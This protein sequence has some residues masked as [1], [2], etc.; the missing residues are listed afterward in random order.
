MGARARE[1]TFGFASKN[2]WAYAINIVETVTWLA[3]RPDYFDELGEAD[4]ELDLFGSIGRARSSKVFEWLMT[5]L[6]YQGISDA[7]ARSYMAAHKQPAWV[8]IARG[9]NNGACPLLQ[10]Y[11]HFHGCGYRKAAQTCAKPDLME[12]CPLPDHEFRNGNLSQLAYSLLLFI[13]DV[14]QG[15]LIDW[16]DRRLAEAR[17]GPAEGRLG[18]MARSIIEPLAGLHGASHKVLNM[19]L[20]DLLLIGGGRNPLWAEVAPSLIAVDSLVHNFLV[21]TGILARARAE[22]PYGPQCYGPTGCASVLS[23]LCEGID[24]RQFNGTFPKIFPRFIQHAIW[25]YCAGDGRNVCN[26]NTIDDQ[27]RCQNKY[28]RFTPIAIESGLAENP[29]K[30]RFIEAF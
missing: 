29:K 27:S 12:T 1:V 17:E 30:T 13:R 3:G 11:W 19:A 23:I 20:S 21:R 14:A 2:D 18:R 15:D 4:E 25:T 28:C 26:G 10:S 6:S 16:I 9:V 22:H 7:V 8:N 5:A 24:A